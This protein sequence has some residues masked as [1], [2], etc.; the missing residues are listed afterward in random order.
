MSLL[1]GTNWI[2][3]YYSVN[4]SL[5]KVKVRERDVW[6]LCLS[7][8]QSTKESQMKTLKVRKKKK[9][10]PQHDCLVSFNIDTHGLKS[11][12]QVAVRYYIE[13]WSHCVTFVFSKLRDKTYLKFSFDSSSYYLHWYVLLVWSLGHG[14]ALD[15]QVTLLRRSF[16][17]F[18][19]CAAGCKPVMYECSNMLSEKNLSQKW[20]Y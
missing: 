9:M 8:M 4:F 7:F 20:H 10:E 18:S 16:C 14:E 12:R 2:F 17:R 15:W 1:H 6:F 11:G 5:R 3:K 13:K 19:A